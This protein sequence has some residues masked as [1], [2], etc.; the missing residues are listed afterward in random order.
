MV[1]RAVSCPFSVV[2]C[3]GICGGFVCG[4]TYTH[5]PFMWC[6]I[7]IRV[8]LRDLIC[9]HLRETH[10]RTSARNLICKLSVDPTDLNYFF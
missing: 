8:Y 3:V 4:F 9:A 6:Q 7:L 2:G 10:P 5:Q 1:E